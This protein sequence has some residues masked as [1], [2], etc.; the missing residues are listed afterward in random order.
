MMPI[1]G[2]LKKPVYALFALS[3]AFMIFDLAYFV[4]AKLPGTRNQMCVIGAGLTTWNILFSLFVSILAGVLLVGIWEAGRR[5][6]LMASATSGIG[7][8][9]GS[10][11][12]FCTACTLPVISLFGVSVSLLLFTEYSVFLKV[13]SFVLMLISVYIVN[14]QLG[15]DCEICKS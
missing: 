5:R 15:D 13:L 1:F 4:M 9:I 3:F 11:T 7:L 10:L 8:L 6:R 12:V 14:K 2:N